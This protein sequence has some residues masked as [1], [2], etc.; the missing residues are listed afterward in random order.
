[1]P[2]D[3]LPLP[4]GSTGWPLVGEALKLGANSFAFMGERTTQHGAVARSRL[5]NKDL[6]ILAGPNTADA[7]LDESNVQRAGGLP[8]H[9]AALFGSGVVNQID[10]DAHRRRKQHLMRALDAVALASYLPEIRSSIRARVHAWTAAG[11]VRLQDECIA[12]TLEMIFANFAGIHPDADALKRYAQGMNDFGRALFGLP[13]ALPGTPLARARVFVTET[14]ALL[15]QIIESRRTNGTTDAISRLIASDVEG[16]R[17]STEDIAKEVL[18][19]TFAASGLWAW[20]CFGAQTLASNA[21]LESRLRAVVATLPADPSGRQLFETEALNAFV[22]EVKRLGLIIPITAVGVARR[23]FEVGG[24]RVPKGWLV[25]WTTYGSHHS[26]GVAPYSAPETFDI[27]RYARGEGTE[28]H[29][30]APQGPGEALT[31]HRCGGVEY[32][33]LALSQFFVELLRA[34]KLRVV[35]QDLT[36]DMSRLPASWKDGLRVRFG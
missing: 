5:M 28:R 3:S 17:L 10:G 34:P 23:D 36:M 18:H 12:L 7:F 1:M 27:D 13:L 35:P 9:A 14:R 26:A 19:L 22:H 20:M 8:P 15:T 29:H 31:S 33:T 25:L 32:S 2:V 4:P 30:F 6:A 11:E 16:E 24:Y 21:A